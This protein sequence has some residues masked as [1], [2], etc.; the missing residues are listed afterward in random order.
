[1][2]MRQTEEDIVVPFL[3]KQTLFWPMPQCLAMCHGGTL[4]MEPGLL[5]HSWI[6]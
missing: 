6:Q 2:A 1:M 5:R 4:N 3:Q